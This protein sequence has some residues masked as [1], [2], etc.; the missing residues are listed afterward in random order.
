[1]RASHSTSVVFPVQ[2]APVTP[3]MRAL[4]TIMPT[5]IV[6]PRSGWVAAALQYGRSLKGKI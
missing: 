2:G 3:S 6:P 1:L 4:A 5:W